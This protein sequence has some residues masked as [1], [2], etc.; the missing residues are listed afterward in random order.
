MKIHQILLKK[1]ANFAYILEDEETKSCM[2]VD[3]A[4]EV[5]RILR[6]VQSLGLTVVGLINTHCHSDH[7]A[8]YMLSTPQLGDLLEE[9]L[10]LLDYT[11]EDFEMDRL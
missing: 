2:L 7:T 11:C 4:F 5:K 1:M 10:A 9:G 8:A 3:P 6:E